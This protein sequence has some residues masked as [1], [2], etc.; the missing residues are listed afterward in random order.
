[1]HYY[2]RFAAH[3]RARQK[4]LEDQRL[5]SEGTDYLE[6]LSEMTQIPV[7]QMKFITDAWEQIVSC[8][9]TLQWT[10]A[11]GFYKFPPTDNKALGSQKDFFEFLQ[12]EAEWSLERLHEEA[13]T[14]L[15][16]FLER[17]EPIE[18]FGSFQINLKGLV[19]VTRDYFDK[20]VTQLEL[21]FDN[22]DEIFVGSV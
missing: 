6:A 4:A 5:T 7:S 13:E 22:L 15:K 20:F 11:Y 17:K 16:C 3:D 1:M 21:G 9:R 2:E 12:G 14:R 8:R 10:Y 19:D 18:N